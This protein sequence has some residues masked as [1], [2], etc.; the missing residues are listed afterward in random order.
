MAWARGSATDF[1]DFLRKFRDYAAGLIDP[2]TDPDITEGVVVPSGDQ[3]TILTNGAGQPSLPGSGMATDGEV[4]LM[5][6]GSDPSDEIIVG[7]K[8][9]R[10]AG[11]NVFGWELRGYTAFNDG[12]TFETMPGTS[13][14]C[15]AS[16]DD[17]A[18]DV[19]FWVNARRLMAI[20]RVGTVDVL[21]HLGFIQQFGTRG[22][23]PYPLLI[24]GSLISNAFNAQTSHFG[25]SSIPDPCENG[26]QLRWVDGTW[27]NVR[28]YTGTSADRAQARLNAGTGL[29]M[30]PQ[31]DP[32]S[33]SSENQSQLG[34]AAALFEGFTVTGVQVSNTEIGVYGLHP[35][36]LMNSTPQMIGRV[37][38]MFIP[39]GAGLTTG[40]TLTVPNSPPDVYDVFKN[41]WRGEQIDY[42]AIL[43]E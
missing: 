43:R 17:A 24:S 40:D 10:N 7:M 23:Y 27:Q 9:Y 22:Q 39:P 36:V 6:P 16:F 41:T 25:H 1:I 31:R 14:S 37:D 12:L 18:F 32:T 35:V 38:G 13:P 26:A 30:W 5:G 15:Y 28:N 19:F 21:V 33:T 8:T 3:W 11:N 29:V 42:F 34:S 4:Y 2:S 20:A